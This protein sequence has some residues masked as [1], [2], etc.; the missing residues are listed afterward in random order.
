[1]ALLEK[2]AGQGH[3]YAMMALGSVHDVRKEYEQAV[4]W[5]TKGAEAGA[6]TRSLFSSTLAVCDAQKHPTHPKCP[7]TPPSHGLHNPYAHPLS[8][9]KRSS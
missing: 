3:A 1:M 8:H 7:L 5:L 9:K 2:A 6:Y 4:K